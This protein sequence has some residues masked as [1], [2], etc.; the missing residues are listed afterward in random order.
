[1]S[2]QERAVLGIIGTV[3]MLLFVILLWP[4]NDPAQE[5]T[6]PI[7]TSPRTETVEAPAASRS[8]PTLPPERRPAPTEEPPIVSANPPEQAPD[9]SKSDELPPLTGL[10]LTFPSQLSEGEMDEQM[11]KCKAVVLRR[12][13]EY[14]KVKPDRGG[15]YD[16]IKSCFRY[17]DVSVQEERGTFPT[18]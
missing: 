2:G 13:G 14:V 9:A 18:P 8:A 12:R 10:I 15:S 3:V 5:N 1:M 16:A 4:R 17:T 11:A 7:V 6:K